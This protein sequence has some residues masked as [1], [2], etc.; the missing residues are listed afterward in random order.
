MLYDCI[1]KKQQ[2]D[3]IACKFIDHLAIY[4]RND[5]ALSLF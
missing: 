3:L 4:Y 5:H 2:F 1:N